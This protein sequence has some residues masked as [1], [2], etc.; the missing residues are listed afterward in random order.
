MITNDVQ[1]RNTKTWLARFEAAAAE[2]GERHPAENRTRMEQLQIDAALA[3]AEDLRLEIS[4]YD[5]LRSGEQRTFE[6]SSLRGIA[7]LLI[8]A[9]VARGWTQRRLADE[10]GI[11][12]QQVQRYESTGYSAASLA[13][14]ADIAEALGVSVTETA[15]LNDPAAA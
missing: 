9:R 15:T 1:C 10:L 7:D 13:R 8:K 14:L 3:Q 11:A 5:Q 12:E 2:L 6:A 4:D